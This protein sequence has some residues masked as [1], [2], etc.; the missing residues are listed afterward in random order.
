MNTFHH[1]AMRR[2]K[3]SAP[4]QWIFENIGFDP[5][6]TLDYGCGRW[7]D[8]DHFGINGWDINGTKW[9]LKDKKYTT[10]LCSYVL[11]V[12]PSSWERGEVIRDVKYHLAED[13]V[14]YITVRN[15]RDKLKG[16]T[17]SETY[18]IFVDLKYPVIHKTPTYLI[19]E[20]KK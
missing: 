15:D 12:I 2:N 20:V 7:D 6:T 8:V 17:K 1:S 18:Q 10:I 16:W 5:D 11:N 13:G 19:Y 3:P 14:A 9:N 4:A